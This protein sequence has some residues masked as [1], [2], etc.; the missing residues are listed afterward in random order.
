MKKESIPSL[1]DEQLLK[2]QET[3]KR[4]LT[5]LKAVAI[6][7]IIFLSFQIGYFLSS[8]SHSFSKGMLLSLF[9]TAIGF[10]IASSESKTINEEI[11]KRNL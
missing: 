3:N 5:I 9:I 6:V 4:S 1:S 10:V 8:D 11:K 7:S 2:E